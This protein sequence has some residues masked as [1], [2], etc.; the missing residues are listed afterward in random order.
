MKGVGMKVRR[1]EGNQER[2]K[3]RKAI[4]TLISVFWNLFRHR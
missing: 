3:E 4:Y 2:E 1:N